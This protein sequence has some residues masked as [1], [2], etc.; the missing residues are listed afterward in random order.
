M[1]TKY[2]EREI[3]DLRDTPYKVSYKDNMCKSKK[4]WFPVTAITPK[5]VE[6]GWR[7]KT[8]RMIKN[9]DRKH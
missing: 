5:D 9:G 6:G 4:E 2:V 3:L 7:E 8:W 1:K